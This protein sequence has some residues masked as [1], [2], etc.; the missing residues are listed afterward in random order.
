MLHRAQVGQEIRVGVPLSIS[1][2]FKISRATITSLTGSSVSE[3]R[4][5]SPILLSKSEPSATDDLTV[6]ERYVPASVT[7]RCRG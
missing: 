6:P 5:V 3:T 2:D 7:P 1:S 4:I